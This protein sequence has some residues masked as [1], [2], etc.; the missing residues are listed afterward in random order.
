MAG[1][2]AAAAVAIAGVAGRERRRHALARTMADEPVR[3]ESVHAAF[4][5]AEP[6]PGVV[7]VTI[8]GHDTGELGDAPFQALEKYLARGKPDIF[9][10]ARDTVGASIDVSAAWASWLLGNKD[11]YTRLHLL[12]GSRYVQVTAKFVHRFTEL[13]DQMRIYTDPAAFEQALRGRD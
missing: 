1:A 6:S 11:R 9:V 5:L 10:D 12:A 3:L 7:L 4:T 2:G 8:T 13:G